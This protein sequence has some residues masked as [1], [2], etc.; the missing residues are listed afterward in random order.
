[1]GG[2]PSARVSQIAPTFPA[3]TTSRVPVAPRLPGKA[4]HQASIYRFFTL[5]LLE[6]DARMRAGSEPRERLLWWETGVACVRRYRS[7]GR[8]G[9]LRPDA[10]GEYQ[11]GGRRVRFWLEWDTGS[12]GLERLREKLERYA[13]YAQ[14]T[15]WRLEDAHSLPVLLIVTP[16]MAQ[17]E[18]VARLVDELCERARLRWPGPLLVRTTTATRVARDGPLAPIWLP[19]L[20][21]MASPYH[22]DQGGAGSLASLSSAQA[23]LIRPLERVP[24][25]PRRDQAP[26]PQ[27]PAGSRVPSAS[28]GG[29]HVAT[30]TPAANAS[31]DSTE[32]G[33]AG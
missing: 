14:T 11:S 33:M 5:L 30:S 3:A 21:Q 18:R 24:P 16:D 19:L 31:A 4:V 6:L 32:G 26:Q 9:T 15:T 25:A 8:W 7:M 1:A 13:T 17:E 22:R 23:P 10:A 20:P 29:Q 2:A 28:T 27:P 12:M